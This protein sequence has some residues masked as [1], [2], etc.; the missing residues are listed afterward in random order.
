[1]SAER[2]ENDKTV[3]HA[4]INSSHMKEKPKVFKKKKQAGVFY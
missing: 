4:N 1:M 3:S 2:Q